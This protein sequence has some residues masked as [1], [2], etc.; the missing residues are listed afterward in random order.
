MS[1]FHDTFTSAES[2]APSRRLGLM[3]TGSKQCFQATSTMSSVDQHSVLYT[4]WRLRDRL[5]M[6]ISSNTTNRKD[7][8]MMRIDVPLPLYC[9][10]SHIP[11]N[12]SLPFVFEITPHIRVRESSFEA[13][14]SVSYGPTVGRRGEDIV[15]FGKHFL[16]ILCN[17]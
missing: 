6:P 10:R 4:A 5:M 14:E 1:S 13:L 16:E 11:R 15:G 17:E 9:H 7:I 12:P 8:I 2:P 3:M